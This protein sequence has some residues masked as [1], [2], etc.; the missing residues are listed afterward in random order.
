[1]SNTYFGLEIKK[2]DDE[3]VYLK[4]SDKFGISP[5]F[6]F[7]YYVDENNN[8]Y[9]LVI[10]KCVM[11][12]FG[13]NLCNS[14]SFELRNRNVFEINDRK[15]FSISFNKNDFLKWKLANA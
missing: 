13:K 15:N 2:Y 14:L 5:V 10:D 12:Y 7:D 4:I 3:K 6:Y 8:V 9:N 11:D 1:M